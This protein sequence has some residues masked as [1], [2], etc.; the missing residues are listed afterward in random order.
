ML[1]ERQD[2]I[3]RLTVEA[4]LEDG[5]P[6]GS[7]SIAEGS[8]LPWSASTI[9]AELSALEAGGYLAQPHTSAGR[10]PTDLGYRRYVEAI[11]SR[12][13][14]VRSPGRSELPAPEFHPAPRREV[15]ETMREATATLAH[16]TDLLALVVAPPPGT[17][18]IH[19]V[20]ALLLQPEVVM[21][22]VIASTGDVTRRSFTFD[23]PVDPGLVKWASSYL[24]ETLSGIALG[25]RRISTRLAGGG[26]GP[27][28]AA[29]VEALAPALIELEGDDESTLYVEGAA[30]LL[31]ERRT[32][33][34]PQLNRLMAAIEER[35]EILAMMRSA[36]DERSVFVWIG[37]ENPRPELRNVSV[38]GAN[39]GLGHRNLGSVGVVGPTR[40]DYESSIRAVTYAARELSRYFEHVY[41]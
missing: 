13:V 32:G 3:L 23:R 30:R 5:R 27:T 7:K 34:L 33:D 38:V 11:T 36:I 19:R 40:M 39:Y 21:V 4:Y 9:R 14:P 24:N 1:S 8:D 12:P 10:I 29:F 15:E 18:T 6:V 2:T 22:I 26:L 31:D 35:A 41:A 16:V 25:A 37:A 17:A 28:E 20:E